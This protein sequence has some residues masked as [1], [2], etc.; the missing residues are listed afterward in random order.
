MNNPNAYLRLGKSLVLVPLALML[1]ANQQ[2][3]QPSGARELRRRV[4]MGQIDAP[5]MPLPDGGSFDFKYV[6][7]AQMYDVLR[8][9][10]SFSTS[11]I[12][13]SHWPY[14]YK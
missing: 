7:N 6:A 3:Q 1:M 2:C 9:T 5:K 13:G 4:Q 10:Q 8:K 11:T 12:S 14:R